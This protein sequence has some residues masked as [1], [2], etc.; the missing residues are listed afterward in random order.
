MVG[1]RTLPHKLTNQ[2]TNYFNLTLFLVYLV[3]FGELI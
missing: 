1:V 3:K 2:N